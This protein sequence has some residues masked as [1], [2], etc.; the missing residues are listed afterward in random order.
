MVI[1]NTSFSKQKYLL[2]KLFCED[3]LL[4]T[5]DGLQNQKV[6]KKLKKE[7]SFFSRLNGDFY[8]FSNT[9]LMPS[10]NGRSLFTG[11][12][13]IKDKFVNQKNYGSYTFDE[14]E[15]GN[16]IL[17]NY[18][19]I[20]A[21]V[22]IKSDFFTNSMMF[23]Y[24]NNGILIVSNNLILVQNTVKK[25][26]PDYEISFENI[27]FNL[28]IADEVINSSNYFSYFNQYNIE[29]NEIVGLEYV[30]PY[31]EL[32]IKENREVHYTLKQIA[33]MY[34]KSPKTD[35]DNLRLQVSAAKDE[36]HNSYIALSYKNSLYYIQSN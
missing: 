16:Y 8:I 20:P 28:E 5:K 36:M 30:P 12:A 31:F 29:K 3:F 1:S 22:S 11:F 14:D 35:F 6:L 24:R 7:F 4:I 13:I 9:E 2:N 32:T 15:I 27:N 23:L 18:N 33:E 10:E 21:S 17:L 25:A 26:D 34:E 19:E